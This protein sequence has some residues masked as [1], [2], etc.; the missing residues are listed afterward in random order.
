M[1]KLVNLKVSS[2]ENKEATRWIELFIHQMV[3]EILDSTYC[4][5]AN[6]L[7]DLLKSGEEYE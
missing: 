2:N 7:E 5:R 6:A 4:S 3:F 1:R